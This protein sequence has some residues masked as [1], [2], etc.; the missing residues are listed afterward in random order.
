[1]RAGVLAALRNDLTTRT[2]ERL[3]QIDIL[4]VFFSSGRPER[5][6]DDDFLAG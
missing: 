6:L 4:I 2:I 1:V 5:A 3:E